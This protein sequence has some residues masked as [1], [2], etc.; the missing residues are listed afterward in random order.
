MT[1][2]RVVVRQQE[3]IGDIDNPRIACDNFGTMIAMHPEYTL[4]DVKDFRRFE[5]VELRDGRTFSMRDDEFLETDEDKAWAEENGYEEPP[6]LRR[7]LEKAVA[8]LPLYLYDHSGITM[9][10]GDRI[11]DP[12]DTS[13]V[14]WIIAEPEAVAAN[15]W[16]LANPEHMALIEQVLRGEV[17][18][19]DNYLVGDIWKSVVECTD[20]AD[21]DE[22]DWTVDDWTSG[23][24]D[25]WPY[26]YCKFVAKEAAEYHAKVS[27]APVPYYIEFAGD[28]RHLGTANPAEAV[29]I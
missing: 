26:D 6:H 22:S 10:V 24:N 16:D 7:L 9:H 2:Y 19:Y 12:W 23:I 4:G 11:I 14:G 27:G 29:G 20:E 28:L 15:G 3:Y 8:V 13:N 18:E 21:P 25:D 5:W 1:K 17:E